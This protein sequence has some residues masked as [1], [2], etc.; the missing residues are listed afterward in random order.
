MFGR[1]IFLPD[2]FRFQ[3][4]IFCDLKKKE[5]QTEKTGPFLGAHV[6]TLGPPSAEKGPL[7]PENVPLRGPIQSLGEGTLYE[8]VTESLQWVVRIVSVESQAALSKLQQMKSVQR[9]HMQR[10]RTRLSSFSRRHQTSNVASWKVGD[11]VFGSICDASHAVE[12]CEVRSHDNHSNPCFV[13][14]E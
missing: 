10:L 12:H 14:Q 5:A 3:S 9:S 13:R 1:S 6:W 11:F 7:R 2:F 8:S 4:F